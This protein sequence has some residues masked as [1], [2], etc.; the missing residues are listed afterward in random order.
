MG[1]YELGGY[2]RKSK[3]SSSLAQIHKLQKLWSFNTH[4]VFEASIGATQ[5]YISKPENMCVWWGILS[6]HCPANYIKWQHWQMPEIL[7]VGWQNGT[8]KQQLENKNKE[9][10]VLEQ[11]KCLAG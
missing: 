10:T 11:W 2:Q 8:E 9:I 3:K 5:N 1:V 7:R 6:M 4:I